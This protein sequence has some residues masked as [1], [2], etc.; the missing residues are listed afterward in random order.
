MVGTPQV[1]SEGRGVPADRPA[2][3]PQK[4]G[5]VLERHGQPL[6]RVVVPRLQDSRERAQRQ[7]TARR[8]VVRRRYRLDAGQD[9]ARAYLDVRRCHTPGAG[10]GA[11]GTCEL[12][13]RWCGPEG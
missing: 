4:Q 7:I 11:R 12:L 2:L 1:S 3:P 6:V 10:L 8:A 13:A 5:T 9:M